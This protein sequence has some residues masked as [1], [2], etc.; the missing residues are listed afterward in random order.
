MRQIKFKAW[1]REQKKIL[2][3]DSL[4]FEK[5]NAIVNGKT[6]IDLMQWIGSTDRKNVDIYEGDIVKDGCGDISVVMWCENSASFKFKYPATG[7]LAYTD[8]TLDLEDFGITPEI[9][10]NIYENPDLVEW[11]K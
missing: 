10:G 1:D 4:V 6:D 5:G 9:I 11:M 3:V 8:S 7:L 2:H